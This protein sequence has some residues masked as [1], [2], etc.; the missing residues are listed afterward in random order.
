MALAILI[1]GSPSAAQDIVQETFVKAL[2][3]RL[4]DTDGTVNGLLGTI[5]Y[6]LALKELKRVGRHAELNVPDQLDPGPDPLDIVLI[7]ERDRL[8]AQAI[9]SLD[10]DHRD[11]LVLRFYGGHSYDEIAGV[12]N[13]PLG[14]VKSRIFIAVRTCRE[15]LRE[16]GV[17]E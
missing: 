9:R 3:A 15:I 10:K 1:T 5:A 11:P 13:I 14:T 12:L 16:K 4:R 6:R 8:V 7:D 17:L 2:D